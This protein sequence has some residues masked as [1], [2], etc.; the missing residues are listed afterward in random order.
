MAPPPP[1]GTAGFNVALDFESIDLPAGVTL[2]SVNPNGVTGRTETPGEEDKSSF[3]LT[4]DVLAIFDSLTANSGL[5]WQLTG[6]SEEHMSELQSLM[7]QSYAVFFLKKKT[8]TTTPHI[9]TITNQ[10]HLTET[11][12]AHNISHILTNNL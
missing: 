1:A 5:R 7:R 6:R 4:E 12:T 11:E 2:R 8:K 3:T 10:N 9:Q